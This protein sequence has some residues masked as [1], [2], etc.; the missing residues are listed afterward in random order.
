[1][2]L[3]KQVSKQIKKMQYHEIMAK[4]HRRKVRYHYTILLKIFKNK[5]TLN[6]LLC[7]LGKENYVFNNPKMKNKIK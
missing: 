2:H 5:E 6:R 4:K 3:S 7:E 1:M